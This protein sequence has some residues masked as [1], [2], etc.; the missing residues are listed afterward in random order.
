MHHHPKNPKKR[1][2]SNPGIPGSGTRKTGPWPIPGNRGAPD[3]PGAGRRGL[4]VGATG[5]GLCSRSRASRGFG[6]PAREKMSPESKAPERAPAAGASPQLSGALGEGEKMPQKTL[7][8]I[9]I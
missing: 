9:Y 6:G 8:Q 4:L 5:P 1:G 7:A 2:K 3:P